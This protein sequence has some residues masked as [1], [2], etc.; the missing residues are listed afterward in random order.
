MMKEAKFVVWDI[1]AN[2]WVSQHRTQRGAL[3]KLH[4]LQKRDQDRYQVRPLAAVLWGA[5]LDREASV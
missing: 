1:F 3:I 5:V 2:H 4:R